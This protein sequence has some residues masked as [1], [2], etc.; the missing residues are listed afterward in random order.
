VYD[1]KEWSYT[2]LSHL[3]WCFTQHSLLSYTTLS[4]L[5]WCFTEHSLLSYT[6]SI[7]IDKTKMLVKPKNVIIILAELIHVRDSRVLLHLICV[8]MKPRR[9]LQHSN[10]SWC[11][12]HYSHALRDVIHSI[13][14]PIVVLYPTFL[15]VDT[16]ICAW[17][18]CMTRRKVWEC[19]V[20]YHDRCENVV[21]DTMVCVW[22][23]CMPTR[24]VEY[25]T[26][27]GVIIKTT[28]I[29]LTTFF[30]PH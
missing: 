4:H 19:W 9:A 17:M 23:L 27:I 11:Q 26:T 14:T 7:H 5:S 16:T 3:S 20:W 25:N 12:A 18:L 1:N 28:G 22:M 10:I 2:T 6:T 29:K 15:V 30:Y 21:N 13:I 24:N 8:Y